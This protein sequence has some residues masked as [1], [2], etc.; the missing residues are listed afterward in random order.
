MQ[1]RGCDTEPERLRQGRAAQSWPSAPSLTDLSPGWDRVLGAEGG[2]EKCP[3]PVCPALGT[4]PYQVRA[5][6]LS[7]RVPQSLV[8]E[9]CQVGDGGPTGPGPRDRSWCVSLLPCR[10]LAPP[11]C[12]ACPVPGP[13]PCLFAASF[14]GLCL[15]DQ[16]PLQ[17]D[18]ERRRHHA[19]GLSE[20]G[21]TSRGTSAL[22]SSC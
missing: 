3:A 4:E 12:A 20:P 21:R 13:G 2:Q 17:A 6:S 14:Q 11:A 8:R 9:R 22:H 10:P 7:H 19:V 16:F 15:P 5:A 18:Q 1:L